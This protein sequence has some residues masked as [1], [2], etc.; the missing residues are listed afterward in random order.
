MRITIATCILL[1]L[2]SVLFAGIN[3]SAQP[4]QYPADVVSTEQPYFIWCDIYNTAQ[5]P[6]VV[7]LRISNVKGQSTEYT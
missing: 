1:L 6:F 2:Q 5:K 7:T 4:L 3:D